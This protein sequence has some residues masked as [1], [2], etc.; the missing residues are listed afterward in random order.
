MVLI[1]YSASGFAQSIHVTDDEL[2]AVASTQYMIIHDFYVYAC[3]SKYGFDYTNLA[4]QFISRCGEFFRKQGTEAQ[5][6]FRVV[7]ISYEVF[8]KSTMKY[9]KQ[10][11]SKEF[12]SNLGRALLARVEDVKVV[13]RGIE[14]QRQALNQLQRL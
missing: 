3:A 6:V 1:G 2:Y 4:N 8:A 7:G 9:P 12:C 13:E 11:L 10:L 5:R 14:T